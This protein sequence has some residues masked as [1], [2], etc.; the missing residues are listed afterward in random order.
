MKWFKWFVD[1]FFRSR[2]LGDEMR[3]NYKRHEERY[4]QLIG[5]YQQAIKDKNPSRA[6]MIGKQIDHH[7]NLDPWQYGEDEK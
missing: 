5:E 4:Y 7:N 1:W 6:E 3:E 2:K